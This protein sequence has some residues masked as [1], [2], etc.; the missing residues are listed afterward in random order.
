M[1]SV[2]ITTTCCAF[3]RYEMDQQLWAILRAAALFILL[4]DTFR[5]WYPSS[6]WIWY[7]QADRERYMNECIL[8]TVF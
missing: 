1:I 8:L 5:E 4:E 6:R 2:E 3:S 7:V